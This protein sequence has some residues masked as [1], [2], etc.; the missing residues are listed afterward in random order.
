MKKKD[1]LVIA[2]VAVL[3]LPFFVVPSVY[4]AYADFNTAHGMIM[5]FIKFAIL[6]T[7]GEMIGLRIRTGNYNQPG[8][9]VIPR[10]IVWGFLGLTIN[11]AFIIFSKGTI[12]LLEY[13]GMQ[14]PG[15][16]LNGNL[17]FAKIL[18]AFC[19]STALNL[20]YAPIMMTLH[21]ITD[22]HITNNGG[23][24]AGLLKPIKMGNI[25]ANMDWRVQWDFVFKKTIPFFWI[26]A[27]TITFLLPADFRV[28]FAAILGIALGVLLSIGSL[29]SAK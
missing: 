17:S 26:P 24:V 29:K 22:T 15:N 10:A 14:N 4:K 8:F 2:I 6:A 9:G 5:S 18:V 16:I 11:M 3:L 21:K 13:L 19:I 28:L 25:M 20:I 27:H 12:P 23:T 7:F 1:I